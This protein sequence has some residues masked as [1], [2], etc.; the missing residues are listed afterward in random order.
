MQRERHMT[1]MLNG[2]DGIKL[3]NLMLP[4]RFEF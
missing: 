1:K 2:V 4:L 3:D